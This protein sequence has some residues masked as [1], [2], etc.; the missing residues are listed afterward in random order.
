[1]DPQ[2]LNSLPEEDK[3]KMVAMIETMQ[4]R[5]SLR[6]YNNLVEKCFS[7]CVN[8][9][10]RKSLEKDEERCVSKCCEKFL[11]HSARVSVRFAELNAQ[12]MEQPP[13]AA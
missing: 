7:E 3:T 4:T 2:L 12:T 1:M 5:D 11:K 6:M 13:P 9:F 10:R 8:S